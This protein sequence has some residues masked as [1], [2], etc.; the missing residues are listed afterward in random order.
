MRLTK[1]AGV[2]FADRA[3]VRAEAEAGLQVLERESAADDRDHSDIRSSGKIWH[4]SLHEAIA[5]SRGSGD[6][7]RGGA[8]AALP[9]EGRCASS[10]RSR[11]AASPTRARAWSPER[12]GA[13]LGQ[14]VVVENR[15]APPAT[16]ARGRGRVRAADGYTLLLGFDG[17]MVIN[18]HVYAKLPFDTLRDF[19]PV[20]KLGDATLHP[21]G[22]SVGA[23]EGP[24]R[25]RR[26]SK[27][28]LLLRHG[29]HRQHAASRRRA[30]RA[31]HRHRADACAVQGRRPGDGRCRR[32]TDPA[33]L[34]RDRDG[35]AV[36]AQR[37]AERPRRVLGA[38]APRS[39]P[40]VP[41]FV[42]SGLDGFVVDS[43][44]GI[45]APAKTPRPVIERL[46][47]EIA[48]VLGEPE[49]R[50]PLRHARHRAGRQQSR[51]VRRADPRRPRALGKGRTPGEHQGRV[52]MTDS[53]APRG[54]FAVL[55]PSTNTSV[56]PEYD[57]MRPWGVTHHHSRLVIPDSRVSD[58]ASFM[59]MMDD[60]R[61]AL[62]PALEAV[63]TCDPDYVVLGMSAETFWDGLE[64]SRELQREA[65]EARAAR[66]GHGL[67]CLPGGA[68]RLRQRHQAARRD[69]ALH[70]GRRP[71]GASLLH[72]VRLRGGEP[73]R[74]EV[75]EPDAHRARV[76]A[77][78][79]RRR[80][81]R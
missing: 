24:A 4:S 60:I 38:R 25:A 17:T 59:L 35:A 67:G 69:H 30:P 74:P 12:L 23:G 72:R 41:T 11:P 42:E 29:G 40:E 73:A 20:T 66:R 5:C 54:K 36:R 76:E 55:A 71:A 19:A 18:P 27:Q 48:A 49:I 13:R 43:W 52:S 44:I 61:G 62:F 57:A 10:C 26:V 34:H 79:A 1:R 32:R 6:R 37:Q 33:R 64:G 56:Q 80:S 46:Q 47:R 21:R 16:S 51:R 75:H 77:A 63:L 22:A 68:A 53:L 58:D 81:S 15:P 14:A 2:G 7:L 50:E 70:A 8:R 31:A 3:P 65:R 39:L 28:P 9:L 78:T 45:L